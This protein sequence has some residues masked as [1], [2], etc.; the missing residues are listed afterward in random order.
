MSFNSLTHQFIGIGAK[1]A[2]GSKLIGMKCGLIVTF[3]ALK[4]G[5]NGIFNKICIHTL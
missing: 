3:H 1:I 4:H 5:L 2:K